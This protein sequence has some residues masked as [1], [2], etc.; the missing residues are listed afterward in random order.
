MSPVASEVVQQT[1]SLADQ[2]QAILPVGGQSMGDVVVVGPHGFSLDDGGWGGEI[3]RAGAR[4]G[5]AQSRDF[6]GQ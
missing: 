4:S 5:G 6:D 1:C 3:R 2:T